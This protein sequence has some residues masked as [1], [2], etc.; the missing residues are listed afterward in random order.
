[1]TPLEVVHAFMA[2]AA[3]RDYDAAME[4]L[5]DDVEYQ[6]MPLPPV[7]GKAA[8]RETLDVIAGG[9][10]DGGAEGLKQLA[11]ELAPLSRDLAWTGADVAPWIAASIALL[12]AGGT[13]ITLRARRARRDRTGASA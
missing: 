10:A 2:A 9:F 13:L 12:A 1:M 4:L 8:V 11:P 7:H 3:V 5:T 6:N